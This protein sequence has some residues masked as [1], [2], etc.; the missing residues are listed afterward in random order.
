MRRWT[1]GRR[2][3][4]SRV[5]GGGFLVYTESSESLSPPPTAHSDGPRPPYRRPEQLVKQTYSTSMTDASTGKVKK[6]HVVAYAAKRPSH[7]DVQHPLPLPHQLPLLANLKVAPGIWPESE[8]RRESESNTAPRRP[9]QV[10]TLISPVH[11]VQGGQGG[12][13]SGPIVPSYGPYESTAPSYTRPMSGPR[14]RTP[15][16]PIGHQLDGLSAGGSMDRYHPYHRNRPPPFTGINEY[17]PR[18]GSLPAPS[19]A[20]S[21]PAEYSPYQDIPAQ[22]IYKDR[23]YADTPHPQS[24]PP[25]GPS[26]ILPSLPPPPH[27]Y[28]APYPTD[29]RYETYPRSNAPMRSP[30]YYSRG[31][32]MTV[33]DT[34]V[35]M[36]GSMYPGPG[37]GGGTRRDDIISPIQSTSPSTSQLSRSPRY[38]MSSLPIQEGGQ[39]GYGQP[40]SVPVTLPPLRLAIDETQFPP[41]GPSTT[42]SP[43]SHALPL[44]SYPQQYPS[45]PPDILDNYGY[46]HA[47]S[48]GVKYERTQ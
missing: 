27:P 20:P 14:P 34:G 23:P 45:R 16:H 35:P 22:S 29:N 10:D 17:P 44:A 48:V 18:R 26:T 38:N 31:P 30:T 37:S 3:G 13:P 43:A 33:P 19:S 41:K 11:G 36:Y 46:P 28:P 12:Q 1:D 42:T 32:P 5:G 9:T 7:S 25:S 24:A 39:S 40:C 8:I 6:F 21:Y 2:W 15:S 4:A 47:A